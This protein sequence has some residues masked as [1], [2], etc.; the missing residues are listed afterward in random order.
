[1]THAKLFPALSLLSL[2]LLAA[3][4]SDNP[5]SPTVSARL[6]D[7]AVE[8]VAYSAVPSG[9]SGRSGANGE[10]SCRE[11]DTLGFSL[12]GIGLGTAPCKA[13][14]TV[15]DLAGTNAFSE[16]GLQNRLVFLQALD[17]D[18]DPGNGVRITAAVAQALA[19]KTLDF[20]AAALGF[21]S[22][23]AALLPGGLNDAYGKPYSERSFS[24][25]RRAGAI[26]HFESTLASEL[27][28]S[29]TSRSNQASAGGDV[30]LTK[31]Q[32]QA[33]ASLHIPY[34]GSNALAKKDFPKGFFPAVG[35]GLAFKGRAAD[36][37]LE[38]W[39]I[40]DRGPNADSPNAP[41][42][43]TGA[44]S[45][46]KIFLS[47]SFTPAI[48]V[49]TVGA[50]GAVLSSLLPLK[51]SAGAKIS[52]RP[53]APGSTGSSG[54]VPLTDA[55][56]YDASTAAY[57]AQGLDSESLVWDA[58][59]KVFWT[60]DEYG[61]FIVKI[62][63]AS[64]QILKRYA[65]GT[66]TG[67]LPEVLKHRRANRGME[68][69]ALDTASGRLHG[70]LQSPIDPLDSAGKSVETTDA[71]DMDQDGKST[72]KVK[73]RDFAQFAR[74]IE[75]DPKTETAKLYAYPLAYPLAA[76]GEKW[77]RN[78]SGSAKLG[79]LV[80]LGNGKFVL[81]E[82]GADANGVV[83]NFLMLVELPAN[84]T[85]IAAMGME[86]EKNSIDGAS[87]SAVSWANLVK[88]KKTVLLDLNA[89]GWTAE[90]AEGLALVDGQ[91][92]ALINDS[93]FGLR[94]SLVDAS[95]KLM[96]GD[97]TECTVNANGQI[98]ADGSCS[99]GAVGVRVTRGSETERH[100][101]LWLLK[102]PKAL[103]G[104]SVP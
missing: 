50:K 91:T 53:L 55:L 69:L 71:S 104:Y 101:R 3:C 56:Q 74:W 38:F 37:S 30:L 54:E 22:S 102:F 33:D 92:L 100:T 75:F 73:L 31:Y 66:A 2:A 93:D 10:L 47:P 6:L 32:L 5:E 52:G 19:G 80:S 81:I 95:G 11:G 42:P 44:S 41:R 58:A 48:G 67:S 103:A 29:D 98:L 15:A 16:L 39:G 20:S 7:S 97:P 90:K 8:G 25:A 61:P 79:D 78:R 35:S 18:D 83:R 72:D 76:K 28:R 12:G 70:F 17:E 34:E 96:A 21:N 87:A 23:A 27:G 89:A 85:D 86:L 82:Q 9:L 94:T 77:D 49:I 26:E 68:G 99:A 60:S 63:A 14:I 43:D 13:S 36:G 4:G 45:I 40:T 59:N 84:A 24:G 65:P 51:T 64:G 88:L 62:D 46:S 57:D 1:M